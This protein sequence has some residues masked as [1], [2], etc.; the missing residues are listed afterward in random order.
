MLENEHG[1]IVTFERPESGSVHEYLKP[2]F[3][4]LPIPP[5][6]HG[7]HPEVPA[8]GAAS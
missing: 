6:T 3:T 7:L 5:I 4:K 2:E 8:S 1:L